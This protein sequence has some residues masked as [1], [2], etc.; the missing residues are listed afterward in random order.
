MEELER[1]GTYSDYTL[2]DFQM[3]RYGILNGTSIRKRDIVSKIAP[4]DYKLLK[5]KAAPILPVP[6]INVRASNENGIAIYT[7][8]YEGLSPEVPVGETTYELEGQDN[9]DP[10]DTHPNWLYLAKKYKAVAE[11]GTDNFDHFKKYIGSAL[12]PLYG[13]RE[14]ISIGLT[15]RRTSTYHD[16]PHSVFGNAGEIDKP[17]SLR[18]DDPQPPVL[19]GRR[20]WLKMAP[21]AVWRGNI[22]LISE[23]WLASG[24]KGFNYDVY[25]FSSVPDGS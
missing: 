19:A 21:R 20:N 25:N 2:G 18:Q 16:L 5:I 3:D 11:P 6:C 14:Y 24:P 15:F 12:N 17:R 1:Y 23:E 13:V 9:H 22:W 10:I 8:T 4:Y 7:Y